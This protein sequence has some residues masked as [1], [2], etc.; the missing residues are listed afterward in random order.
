VTCIVPILIY[1]AISGLSKINEFATI[2]IYLFFVQSII[3]LLSVYFIEVMISNKKLREKIALSEKTEMLSHLAASISHEIRN[4]LTVSKGFIQL[5]QEKSANDQETK[6]YFNHALGE[7][8][9]ANDIITNY[10]SFA[11]PTIESET[12]FDVKEQIDSII[13]IINPYASLYSAIIINNLSS[14]QFIKVDSN[15]FKQ[16]FF[17]IIKNSIEAMP[18]GGIITID[19]SADDKDVSIIIS[20]TGIGMTQ[21]QIR[22]LGQPYFST[23]EKGTG[24]GMMV[25]FSFIK[26]MKGQININS[27]LNIGTT[28]TITFPKEKT[29]SN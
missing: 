29:R 17:N 12:I 20:D 22:R 9:R 5:I 23:K 14:F 26:A 2:Q 19:S 28:F 16:I 6:E 10:L 25:A 15:K 13:N 18:D 1:P 8:D 7:L 24:L 4:P 21:E 11:K 3:L 27:K